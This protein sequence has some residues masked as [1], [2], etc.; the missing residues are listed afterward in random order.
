MIAAVQSCARKLDTLIDPLRGLADKIGSPLVDLA[1]RL[2]M[3]N[4]FFHAGWGKFQNFLNDDWGSTLFLFQDVH[5]I[6]GVPAGLAAIMGTGGELVLS[7]L[8]AVGLFGRFGAAGLIVMTATIQFLVPAEYGVANPE[9]YI[10]ILLL[11]V[12]L[13][14]GPGALSVDALIHRCLRGKDV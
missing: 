5:P 4:I 11:S 10:W 2:Y 6:P 7:V 1:V 12:T 13:I 3:A 9:H 14:K 8:L